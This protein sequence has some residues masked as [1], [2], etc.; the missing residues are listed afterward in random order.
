MRAKT[1][2]T[3]GNNKLNE[4]KENKG[5]GL[6][7]DVFHIVLDECA[8]NFDC[9][10]ADLKSESR[11]ANIVAARHIAM[12]ILYYNTSVSKTKLSK[13]FN[14]NHATVIHALS[15]V[16]T[17]K[18][19]EKGFKET[20]DNI[21][22]NINS[23]IEYLKSVN[24]SSISDFIDMASAWSKDKGLDLLHCVRS[25]YFKMRDSINN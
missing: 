20:Y 19:F 24:T 4:M 7:N 23:E 3:F 10:S 17:R 9:T 13:M 22:S 14:R 18:E 6:I 8:K 1:L 15:S 11:F 5:F 21:F 16:E 12:H 25:T 2:K